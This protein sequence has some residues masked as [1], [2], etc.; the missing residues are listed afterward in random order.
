M[1]FF[2]FTSLASQL[3]RLH[4]IISVC[5]CALAARSRALYLVDGRWGSGVNI[6]FLELGDFCAGANFEALRD[7]KAAAS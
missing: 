1:C 4:K 2:C 7:T 3:Q 5:T 6:C